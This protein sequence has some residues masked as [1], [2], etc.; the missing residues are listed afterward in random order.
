MFHF[1]F[2]YLFSKTGVH[3]FDDVKTLEILL[4]IYKCNASKCVGDFNRQNH[5]F[6]A[7]F[8]H[9]NS[10]MRNG[11]FQKYCAA[12]YGSQV[13]PMFEDCMY[14]FY[15]EWRITINKVRSPLDHRLCPS[16][17]CGWVYGY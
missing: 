5:M 4:D 11:L 1:N 12:F 16:P 7:N 2:N 13:L 15:I 9:A 10:Y 3:M 14:E 6:V 8:K 17:T